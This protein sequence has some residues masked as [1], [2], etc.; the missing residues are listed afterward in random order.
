[1]L[2]GRALKKNDGLTQKDFMCISL[3]VNIVF[4]S[5]IYTILYYTEQIDL[6]LKKCC[7]CCT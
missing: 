3:G 6:M 2:G 4:I 7:T 5:T 1:M